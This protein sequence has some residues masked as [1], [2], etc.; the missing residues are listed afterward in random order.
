VNV[1]IIGCGGIAERRV[2]PALSFS[3]RVRVVAVHDK[4]PEIARRVAENHRIPCWH[5]SEADLLHNDS[6]D[7]VYVASPV[8]AHYDQVRR[9][10]SEGKHVL[11]EKPLALNVEMAAELVEV[12]RAEGVLLQ[13]GFMMRYHPLHRM[14]HQIIESGELGRPVFARA[15][16]SCWY[17][18]ITGA[19]RQDPAKGGGGVLMDLTIHTVDLLRYLF[20]EVQAVSAMAGNVVHPYLV[21][22]AGIVSLVF[23]SGALAFCDS[24]FSLPDSAVPQTL[25]VYGTG[26]SVV[27]EGTIGQLPGGSG[28]LRVSDESDSYDDMQERAG[29][30]G[31]T[32][33]WDPVDL[34][35]AEFEDFA[36]SV[37]AGV[38]PM[39][40]GQEALETQRVIEAAYQ[41]SRAKR[42]VSLL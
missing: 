30:Q 5:T 20:G 36:E 16:L 25:E 12:C 32:L 17:P 2:V 6:L 19:W 21:E 28:R 1:G 38:A 11:C 39:N 42:H 33:E 35:R 4:V 31:R 7:A 23:Q 27:A 15:Q 41:S 29:E 18:P 22:D 10:A 37:E 24:F 3:G 40:C 9:A 8:Y 34:Y 14:L 13:V 26:G